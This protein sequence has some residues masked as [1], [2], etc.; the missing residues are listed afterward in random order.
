MTP[1]V[2]V[3]LTLAV[4]EGLLGT[5]QAAAQTLWR[6]ED[7][8]GTEIFTDRPQARTNCEIYQLRSQT[9]MVPKRRDAEVRLMVPA[10]VRTDRVIKVEP[11]RDEAPAAAALSFSALNRLSVGM[12]EAE[13]ANIAGAPKTKNIDSWVYRLSDDSVVELRFG[14]G[15]VVEIKQYQP[16]Q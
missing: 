16:A 12:T 9:L 2:R 7:M 8:G 13:V 5:G 6:C 10:D 3:L 14:S 11:R 4:L 15:R 1:A